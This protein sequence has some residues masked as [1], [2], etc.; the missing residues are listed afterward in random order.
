MT[1]KITSKTTKAT[2]EADGK[3]VYTATVTFNGK[4]YTDIKTVTI[5]KTGHKFGEWKTTGFN[6]SKGTS[7]QKRVCSVC[8]KEE[9]QTVS[10]SYQR[11]LG[12]GRYATAAEISKAGF[13]SA[14]TVILATGLTYQDALV[15]VPLAS[16]YDAPLLLGTERHITAQTEAE[17]KRLKTEQSA[18]RQKPS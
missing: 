13:H 16:A 12:D 1:A 17:I 7:T 14:D 15:A 18:I 2:C 5:T 11:V 4:T 3:T 6:I 9:T 8:M 10:G